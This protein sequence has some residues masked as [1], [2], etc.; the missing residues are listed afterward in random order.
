MQIGFRQFVCVGIRKGFIRK[1]DADELALGHHRLAYG[2]SPF[3][4]HGL[5]S[6]M[7]DG[8]SQ[9]PGNVIGHAIIVHRMYKKLYIE[10]TK[11]IDAAYKGVFQSCQEDAFVRRS[12][13]AEDHSSAADFTP[14]QLSGRCVKYTPAVSR[15]QDRPMAPSGSTDMHW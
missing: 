14:N 13:I 5:A 3:Q 4:D 11:N 15:S 8:F 12:R 10:C 9:R 2:A 1:A 7:Q 6:S